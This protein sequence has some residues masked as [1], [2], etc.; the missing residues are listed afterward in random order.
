MND[1]FLSGIVVGL[2]AMLFWTPQ[3]M[4]KG[5][6]KLGDDYSGGNKVLSWI[7]ILNICM[8]EKKYYGKLSVCTGSIISLF[9]GIGAR[10]ACW[11]F[12]YDN[13]VVAL[14][15]TILFWIVILFYFIANIIF[16]YNVIHDAEAVTG[17]KLLLLVVFYP[18][19]QYYVG[20]FLGNV[21]R[22]AKNRE[23]TF[24]L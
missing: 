4:F 17:F 21:L 15:S 8:A 1:L 16:V 2:L 20:Q 22:H 7:P 10:V 12:L 18:F 11:W 19:G 6:Y 5:V 9:V 24:K 23:E 14:A 13:K 3:L